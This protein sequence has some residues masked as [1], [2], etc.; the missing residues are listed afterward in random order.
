[1]SEWISTS[2]KLPKNHVTIM[3][4][5]VNDNMIRIGALYAASGKFISDGDKYYKDEVSHW[6]P[7]PEPPK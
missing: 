7:L 1:M 4:W 6:M 2:N 3:F 5:A